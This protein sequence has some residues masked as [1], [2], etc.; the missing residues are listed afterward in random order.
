MKSSQ[1]SNA[2]YSRT[3]VYIDGAHEN[4]KHMFVVLGNKIESG[5]SNVGEQALLDVG[6]AAGAFTHYMA[7]RFP[8]IR[9]TCL[10]ADESLIKKASSQ[11]SGPCFLHGDANDMVGL[12][13]D[14]FDIVTMTGTM[15][16]FDDFRPS[17]NECIRVCKPGGRIFITGQF[18][19]FPV[20]ALI[21][22][23]YTGDSGAY[24]RGYNLF[25]KKSVSDHLES[26]DKVKAWRYEKFMLPFDLERQSDPIRSWTEQDANG[27]RI[28]KNGLQM[29][30]NLQILEIQLS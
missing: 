11:I 6:G 2:S 16:I 19:E 25:S 9:F 1:R 26:L 29:E 30:I 8:G 5:V 12:A 17:L 15:S 20:D 10:D 22:W 27:D 24:N 14:A 18:N 21:Q 13:A 23:R 3:D 28:F 4:P 7:R